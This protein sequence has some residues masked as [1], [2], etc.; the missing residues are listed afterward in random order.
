LAI[1]YCLYSTNYISK[2]CRHFW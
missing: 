1:N 2:Y